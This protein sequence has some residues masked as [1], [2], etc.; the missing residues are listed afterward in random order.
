MI[1]HIEV[2]KLMDEAE[3]AWTLAA[4]AWRD[5]LMGTRG[6]REAQEVHEI[7]AKKTAESHKA[8]LDWEKA[9]TRNR[10]FQ[11]ENPTPVTTRKMWVKEALEEAPC[12][13]ITM[14][15]NDVDLTQGLTKAQILREEMWD[16]KT[17]STIWVY[18]IVVDEEFWMHTCKSKKA[19]ISF[20]K[21]MGWGVEK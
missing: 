11:N 8:Y 14:F 15:E 16:E 3:D 4:E 10:V 2:F 12:T 7:A 9:T 18:A 17:I 6:H 1:T 5:V 20:C 21:E 19:A 13:R